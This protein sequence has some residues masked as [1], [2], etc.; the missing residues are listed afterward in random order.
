MPA[1]GYIASG[2]TTYYAGG[3]LFTSDN[4][5]CSPIIAVTGATTF[6]CTV[7]NAFGSSSYTNTSVP[8][9]GQLDGVTLQWEIPQP[10]GG[11]AVG[12]EAAWLK[13]NGQPGAGGVHYANIQQSGCIMANEY[14]GYPISSTCD[15]IKN[16]SIYPDAAGYSTQA[17]PITF[18]IA[19]R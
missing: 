12:L 18:N 16:F 19:P 7:V 8:S 1:S 10:A 3:F 4:G 5:F 9:G 11:D 15:A 2:G 17:D 6:T 13:I 14:I